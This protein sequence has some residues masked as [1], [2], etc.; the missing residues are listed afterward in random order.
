MA[1]ILEIRDGRGV[2]SW[3][4]LDALPLAIGRAPSNDIILDDPYTDARH[5]T[6]DRDDAGE[7]RIADLG[8][9]NGLHV[10]GASSNG[11]IA[12]RPGTEVRIGRTLLRFRA[13]DEAVPPA[14][15][16]DRSLAAAVEQLA[17]PRAASRRIH[18]LITTTV[19]RLLSISAMIAAF[20]LSDWLGESKRASGGSV[21]AAALAAAGMA[22]VWA[23]LWSIAGRGTDRRTHFLGHMAVVS[24]AF[25]VLLGW[26]A[27]NE[28]LAFL[29][30][31]A[32]L[33]SVLFFAVTVVLIAALVAG[34]LSVTSTMSR[35]RRWRVG[36]IAAG[37][38]AALLAIVA[39]I[40][41]DDKFSD[42][43]KFA[44]ELKPLSPRFVP[45]RSVDTFASEF[46]EL[47][48][49]VDEKLVK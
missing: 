49:K 21:M 43:P 34:H 24:L 47:K 22:A 39:I 25:I 17:A 15:V 18:G 20:A 40:G 14:L 29:F 1:L 45:T 35:Q 13:L 38:A 42:V 30:P 2:A 12:I 8:S 36:F 7:L 33:S 32:T 3:H 10:L 37:T 46:V 5:A 6:I 28:W 44:A 26:M 4:R 27:V 19:G 48:E 16:D 23:A 41:D 11:H 31:N 9:V